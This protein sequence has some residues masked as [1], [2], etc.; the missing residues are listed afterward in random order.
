[1]KLPRLG[2]LEFLAVVF[3][4]FTVWVTSIAVPGAWKYGWIA[5]LAVCFGILLR[6]TLGPGADRQTEEEGFLRIER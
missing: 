6:G 5:V 1:M 2:K 3:G 4:I